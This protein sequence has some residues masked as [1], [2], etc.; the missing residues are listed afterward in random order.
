[1]KLHE[2]VLII[3]GVFIQPIFTRAEALAP[4]ANVG[5]T[6]ETNLTKDSERHGSNS[7]S[8]SSH[9]ADTIIERVTG[10]RP[11]GV[12]L[13][14]DLPKSATA[15]ER[16]TSWQFPVRVLKPFSGPVQLLNAADLE[17]RV[18][19]W[20]KAAG[21]SRA[22]CGHWIFTWNAFRIECDPQSVLNTIDAFDLT[23]VDLREGALYHDTDALGSG[24]LVRKLS[25]PDTATFAVEL[26][27]DPDSVRRDRAESDVVV[28]EI[29]HKPVTF[30]A[31][32]QRRAK[33]VVSGTIAVEFETDSAGE[34]FRRSRIKKIDVKGSDGQSETETVTEILERRPLQDAIN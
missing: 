28:G 31:A 19:A 22:A 26:P 30:D 21:L 34:P 32:F 23:A 16:A 17:S 25:G 5:D 27:I 29:M 18:D 6:F 4:A 15:E 20:L 9:D 13:Q 10:L 11:D 8:G 2:F 3:A 33:D 12:E 7:S 1:M 24:K 14:Y